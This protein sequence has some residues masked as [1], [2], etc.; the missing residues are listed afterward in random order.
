MD[1]LNDD[2]EHMI[3]IYTRT[4]ENKNIAVEYRRNKIDDNLQL[5]E[6]I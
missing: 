4:M 5:C 6:V 1:V 3:T 2:N